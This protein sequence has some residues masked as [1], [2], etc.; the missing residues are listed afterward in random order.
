MESLGHTNRIIRATAKRTP[1]IPELK[2]SIQ[3]AST[4]AEEPEGAPG[5]CLKPPKPQRRETKQSKIYC[6]LR[7]AHHQENKK[8]HHAPHPPRVRSSSQ[9]KQRVAAGKEHGQAHEALRQVVL[10]EAVLVDPHQRL[11]PVVCPFEVFA[12]R[13]QSLP[14]ELSLS[15]CQLCVHLS[16]RPSVYEAYKQSE[17]PRVKWYSSEPEPCRTALGPGLGERGC[18]RCLRFFLF[19][20]FLA[21]G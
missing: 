10:V 14:L 16:E 21:G 1:T 19:L 7:P 9:H 17:S 5:R 15:S 12:V 18:D 4:V 3:S 20:S 13:L 11:K 2:P 8:L 6:A